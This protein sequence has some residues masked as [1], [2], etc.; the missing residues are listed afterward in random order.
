MDNSE[1]KRELIVKGT[2]EVSIPPDLLIIEMNLSVMKLKY[3]EA[4]DCGATQID[5]LRAAI[6]SAGHE[7]DALK[8]GSF[9]I[10]TRYRHKDN[11]YKKKRIFCG[12]VCSHNLTLEFDI[13]MTILGETLYAIANCEANPSFSIRFSV[14]DKNKVLDQLLENAVEDSKRKAQVLAK[15]AGVRI[16]AIQRIVFDWSEIALYSDTDA[17]YGV[18]CCMDLSAARSINIKPKDIDV[19]DTATIIWEIE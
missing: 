7:G 2:G 5:T 15:A 19:G 8:T 14:K 3:E 18:A 4:M 12:Y 13:D 9:S 10:D 6:V 16:G 17:D 11:D 1:R